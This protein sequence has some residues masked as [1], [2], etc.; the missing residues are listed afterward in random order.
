MITF[1][2]YILDTLLTLDTLPTLDTL[3]TQDTLHTLDILLNKI[4]QIKSAFLPL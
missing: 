2:V 4:P 1:P 3:H